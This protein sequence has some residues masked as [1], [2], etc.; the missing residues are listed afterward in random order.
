MRKGL[1]FGFLFSLFFRFEY[2]HGFWCGS[3]RLFRTQVGPSPPLPRS[4]ETEFGKAQPETDPR[5]CIE[6]SLSCFSLIHTTC[7]DSNLYLI[8]LFI[9]IRVPTL[10]RPPVR[11]CSPPSPRSQR[12]RRRAAAPRPGTKFTA[13]FSGPAPP[14]FST[15]PCH[16]LEATR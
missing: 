16:C 13:V 10:A 9:Y 4:P 7:F 1:L 3:R 15:R 12:S 14:P 5:E 11:T 6:G 2:P 8:D